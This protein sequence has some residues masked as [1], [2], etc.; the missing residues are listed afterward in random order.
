[1]TP[2]IR[3]LSP[4]YLCSPDT[5]NED[6][7]VICISVCNLNQ[8]ANCDFYTCSAAGPIDVTEVLEEDREEEEEKEEGPGRNIIIVTKHSVVQPFTCLF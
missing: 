6:L 5:V 8:T 7:C 4:K 2:N 3:S 1:M